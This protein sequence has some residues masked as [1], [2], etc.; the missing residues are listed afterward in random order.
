V[1]QVACGGCGAVAGAGA[2][3]C[4]TC[5]ARLLPIAAGSAPGPAAPPPF[6][7][8]PAAP[9]A[10][11]AAPAAPPAFTAAP[12]A[13]PAFTAAPAAQLPWERTITSQLGVW[14]IVG[15]LILATLVATAVVIWVAQGTPAS[16]TGAICIPSPV[17]APLGDPDPFRSQAY[18]YSLD[19]L[20]SCS[21]IR[22]DEKTNAGVH[23]TVRFDQFAVSDWPLDVRGEP[24]A[25]RTAD[26]IVAEAVAAKYAGATLVYSIPMAE[27][28]FNPGSGAVYDL[29]VGAGN[30]D[31]VHARAIV[32]AAVRGDLAIVLESLGPWVSDA[33]AGHPNPAQT[34][35]PVCFSGVLTSVTWPGETPP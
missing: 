34:L 2:A 24:A 3:F 23:W 29:Y 19:A 7:A 35:T 28:G 14:L 33:K 22:V 1:S 25:G 11:T 32:M 18:G 16:C 13:P 21:V 8:A 12:A 20:G 17:S 30:A 6:A 26:Q 10:F 4:S 31:P 15:L 27:I 5:G 9:P